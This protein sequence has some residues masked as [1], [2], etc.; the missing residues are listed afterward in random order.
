M[1]IESI[2]FQN[3]EFE[4]RELKLFEFGDVFISTISLNELLINESGNYTSEEAISIDEKIFYFVDE[5][6]IELSEGELIKSVTL[7]LR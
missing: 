7:E 6:E 3:K 5:N 2:K 1:N 4:V